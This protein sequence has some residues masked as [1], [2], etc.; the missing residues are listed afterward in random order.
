LI[1]F[2]KWVLVF[3]CQLGGGWR[4][5]IWEEADGGGGEKREDTCLYT[6]CKPKTQNGEE[7]REIQKRDSLSLSL[8]LTKTK[9]NFF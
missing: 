1:G 2:M 5:A 7:D 8:S 6:H 9:I 3:F 4:R